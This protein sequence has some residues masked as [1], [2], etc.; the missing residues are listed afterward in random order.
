MTLPPAAP[1]LQPLPWRPGD[2]PP[3][4]P[5]PAR[6]LPLLLLIDRRVPLPSSPWQAMVASLSSAER[7]R[8]AAFRRPADQHRFLVARAALRQLLGHWQEQPPGA[9]AIETGPHGKPHCAG[10]PAFNLSHSGDLILLAFS[11]GADVGV[12]V[13]VEHVRPNLNWLPIARHVLLPTEVAALEGLPAGEQL[14]AFLGAWCRLEARLKARGEGLAGLARLRQA[15]HGG[16]GASSLTPGSRSL[17]DVAVPAGYQAAAA[18]ESAI[19]APVGE[20]EG[21]CRPSPPP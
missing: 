10:A 15:D 16:D 14:E 8:Q 13:D 11:S 20:G 3:P 18:L 9:V 2:S 1:P 6:A 5:P 12:G 19:T 17:W 4:P 21:A 7:E